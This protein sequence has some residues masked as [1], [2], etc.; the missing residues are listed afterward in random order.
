MSALLFLLP[1]IIAV[2]LVVFPAF[3]VNVFVIVDFYTP[4]VLF[5]SPLY[6]AYHNFLL[7][8]LPDREP[9][10]LREIPA[11]E[12]SYEK[13]VELTEGFS[14]PLI[15][16]GLLGKDSEGVKNWG[17]PDWWIQ[18]YGNEEL[19]C[20][21]FTEDIDDCTVK[22]FFESAKNG[23]PFYVTGA[24]QIF[25][26]HPELFD[27]IDSPG[28]RAIEPTNRTATQIFIGLPGMGSDIHSAIGVNM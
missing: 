28:I 2:T 14:F 25:D 24:S 19:L 11:S 7:S 20:G 13:I 15:I 16:R 17:N 21:H 26:K 27:M 9:I 3:W 1:V 22:G 8:Q 23:K 6:D 10:P 18:N 4:W 12:A 5:D